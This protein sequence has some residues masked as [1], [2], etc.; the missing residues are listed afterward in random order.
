MES[1]ESL[2]MALELYAGTIILVSHDRQFVSALATQVIELGG[3]RPVHFD[4]NYEDY[5][6]ARGID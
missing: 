1:I 5:L 3:S 4:G 2:Q 6:K